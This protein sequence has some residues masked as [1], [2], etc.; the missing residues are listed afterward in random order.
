M[1]NASPAAQLEGQE[2]MEGKEIPDEW[3]AV[4]HVLMLPKDAEPALPSSPS[5][6]KTIAKAPAYKAAV[7]SI[8]RA[9]LSKYSPAPA[10]ASNTESIPDL[11][12]VDAKA[13]ISSLSRSERRKQMGRE[14]RMGEIKIL[15]A[16]MGIVEGWE[17]DEEEEKKNQEGKWGKKRKA[18][19]SEG[20]EAKGGKGKRAR[21]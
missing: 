9:R 16:W 3:R 19:G 12:P 21:R 5:A 6:M 2:E 1:P 7:L 20:K 8:L 11:V 4:F 13:P 18:A 14:V 10:P 17:V 15:E